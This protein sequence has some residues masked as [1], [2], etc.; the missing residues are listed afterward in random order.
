MLTHSGSVAAIYIHRSDSSRSE[1]DRTREPE[2][3]GSKSALCTRSSVDPIVSSRV[4]VGNRAFER[5][6][7]I[8]IPIQPVRHGILANL[9]GPPHR[10]SSR[11]VA[12]RPATTIAR[13]APLKIEGVSSAATLG[14]GNLNHRSPSGAAWILDH[15]YRSPAVGPAETEVG[16]IAR[17]RRVALE[18]PPGGWP[19]GGGRQQTRIARDF[20]FR[21]V[22]HAH[23]DRASPVPTAARDDGPARHR[24][25]RRRL[26]QHR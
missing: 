24:V 5:D 9:N 22:V 7:R 23:L 18:S 12:G 3:C 1:V 19:A 26:H 17:Q 6:I 14:I 16:G 15:P 13:P 2:P 25:G 8:S 11:P 4:I 21:G 10:E 20:D